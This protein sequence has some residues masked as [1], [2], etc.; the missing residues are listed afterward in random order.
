MTALPEPALEPLPLPALPTSALPLPLPLAPLLDPLSP[1]P[2]EAAAVA[3]RT[4]EREDRRRSCM[5]GYYPRRTPVPASGWPNDRQAPMVYG[6]DYR[7]T[8]SARMAA[9]GASS[10]PFSCSGTANLSSAFTRSS[11]S[12]S[13]SASVSFMPVCVVRM[14]LP[15]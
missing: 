10:S 15:L 3:N 6:L 7:P 5:R 14:S 9:S 13:K 11:T 12:A 4:S 1:Q 8:M 2:S